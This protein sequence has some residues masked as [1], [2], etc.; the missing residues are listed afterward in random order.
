MA[1]EP[2]PDMLLRLHTQLNVIKARAADLQVRI[3]QRRVVE[4]AK[5]RAA[6]IDRGHRFRDLLQTAPV[7]HGAALAASYRL[8]PA[9]LAAALEQFARATLRSISAGPSRQRFEA[10]VR[11]QQGGSRQ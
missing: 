2:A 7:R 4:I 5:L 8:D 11:Q 10:E 9:A 1:I 3:R 6:A